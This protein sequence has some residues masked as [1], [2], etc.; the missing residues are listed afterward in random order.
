M[1]INKI[2]W[3]KM[4][5]SNLKNNI[6]KL[7][8]LRYSPENINEETGEY[9]NISPK[10]YYKV[11]FE[12]LKSH[13]INAKYVCD[14]EIKKICFEYDT[15]AFKLSE[16]WDFESKEAEYHNILT[17]RFLHHDEILMQ[18]FYFNDS[19]INELLGFDPRYIRLYEKLMYDKLLKKS[20]MIITTEEIKKL[21]EQY[22]GFS[23]FIKL[24]TINVSDIDFENFYVFE[25]YPIINI[26]NEYI[27]SSMDTL[28]VNYIR[29]L[30]FNLKDNQYF[31]KKKGD[32]FENLLYEI[33]ELY[34]KEKK[35]K[36]Y[37]N[38]KFQG[39]ECD[40]LLEGEN[41][42]L[43]IEAKAIFVYDSYK[44]N[45]NQEQIKNNIKDIVGKTYEQSTKVEKAILSE[46]DF[47]V[48]GDKIQISNK[49][50]IIKLGVAI[51][52][53][54][55]YKQDDMENYICFSF[56]DFLSMN[57]IINEKIYSK[58]NYTDIFEILERY[59]NYGP[60]KDPLKK[61]I[62]L[63]TN[64]K[65]FIDS[66][67]N[68]HGFHCDVKLAAID[69]HDRKYLKMIKMMSKEQLIYNP[70]PYPIFST[71]FLEGYIGLNI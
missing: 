48:D 36:V 37:K 9:N 26:G 30:N 42:I 61:I 32:E 43:I 68:M 53:H 3:R 71:K 20:I 8:R 19:T 58:N 54:F 14:N 66:T 29:I 27:C 55:G 13:M 38:I 51:E 10:N 35:Y 31:K 60:I 25:D 47:Y 44:R 21:E 67:E 4:K 65:K 56:S 63:Q 46:K 62:F 24:L 28:I 15:E 11:F 2:V 52:S 40:L 17:S 70:P 5:K 69:R 16:I 45:I 34:N 57:E 23:N 49:K 39:N 1:L 18:R 59:L 64:D 12:I 6:K 33:V 22:K 41:G 7:N 50:K